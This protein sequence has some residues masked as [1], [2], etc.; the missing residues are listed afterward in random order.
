MKPI[1]HIVHIFMFILDK[2]LT[3]NQLKVSKFNAF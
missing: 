3:V 1:L 2:P